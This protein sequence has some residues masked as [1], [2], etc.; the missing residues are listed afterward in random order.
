MQTISYQTNKQGKDKEAMENYQSLIDRQF[1][2]A[3][4]T[5]NLL[6]T[7][8]LKHDKDKEANKLFQ[9]MLDRHNHPAYLALNT[10]TYNIMVNWKFDL[11]K[12]DEAIEAEKLFDEMPKRLVYPDVVTYDFL[13]DACFKEGRVDDAL[14]YFDSSVVAQMKKK[15]K[16]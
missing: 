3:P 5:C 14:K 4:A 15:K 2:M 7:T 12:F 10:E 16:L 8:L 11:Q 9:N 6:L 1:N 13:V